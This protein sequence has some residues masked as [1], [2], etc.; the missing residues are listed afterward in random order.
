MK[1]YYHERAP[2]YDK[3]YS[4]PE[5]QKDL[6]NLEQYIPDQFK[7]KNI[8]EIAAG[9]GYWTQFIAPIAKTVM[10]VDITENVLIQVKRRRNT[11]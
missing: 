10:A 4:Y 9:T 5:R 1:A 2:I 6:R 8:L 11:E 7:D 3:V